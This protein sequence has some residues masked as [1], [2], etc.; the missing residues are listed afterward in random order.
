MKSLIWVT[1]QEEGYHSYPTAP[2]PV[3]HLRNIHRHLFKIKVWIEVVHNDRD[4]E[5]L[6]FKEFVQGETST[7]IRNMDTATSCEMISDELFNRIN[8]KYPSREVWIE[9]SEDGENG[10]LKIYDDEKRY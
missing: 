3:F 8:K 2:E 7:I 5:F 4:I 10:S 9:V 6:M 1:V